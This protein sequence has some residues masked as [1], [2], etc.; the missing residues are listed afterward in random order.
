MITTMTTITTTTKK[1]RLLKSRILNVYILINI[2]LFIYNNK[3]AFIIM[4]KIWNLIWRCIKSVKILIIALITIV[5]AISK[6]SFAFAKCIYIM[7]T[8]LNKHLQTINRAKKTEN[9]LWLIFEC[10]REE[11]KE[12]ENEIYLYDH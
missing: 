5:F 12:V 7:L 6:S 1:K 8:S 3:K 11:R 10:G 9:Y 4:T 2:A